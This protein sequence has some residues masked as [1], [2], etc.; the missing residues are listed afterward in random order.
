V[1]TRQLHKFFRAARHI[2]KT[3]M[4]LPKHKLEKN[5]STHS[6]KDKVGQKHRAKAEKK[7]LKVQKKADKESAM[8]V[9]DGSVA[10][11]LT[12]EQ[13]ALAKLQRKQA[14]RA[15]TFYKK[16]NTASTH[17]NGPRAVTK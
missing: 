16:T 7:A 8:S 11:R 2:V 1:L 15:N 5:K 17:F 13:K 3:N 10:E 9:D 12:D 6:Q 14:N 4:R